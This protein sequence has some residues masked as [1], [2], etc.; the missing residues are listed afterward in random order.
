[1][2]KNTLILTALAL[3]A[4]LSACQEKLNNNHNGPMVSVKFSAGS[5]GS[6]TDISSSGVVTWNANDHLAVFTDVDG[7]N[8]YDFSVSALNQAKTV[9]E[10]SGTVPSDPSRKAVYALYPY[11]NNYTGGPTAVVVGVNSQQISGMNYTFMAGKGAVEGDNFDGVSMEMK[12]LTWIYDV[13]ITNPS[14]K[15]IKAVHFV[16]GTGVFTWNGTVDLTADDPEVSP[17]NLR[18]TMSVVFNTAR[19]SDVTARFALFPLSCTDVDF[20][21]HVEFEDGFYETFALGSRSLN[22]AAGVRKSNTFVLGKGTASQAPWG[23]Y[24]V[25]SGTTIGNTL[26]TSGK[27]ALGGNGV[28]SKLYFEPGG[29]FETGSAKLAPTS[30]LYIASDPDNKPTFTQKVSSLLLPAK[31]AS[32]ETISF[33]NINLVAQMSLSESNILYVSD[34]SLTGISIGSIVFDGCSF[35]DYKNSL[36]R[37]VSGLGSISI[38]SVSMN[39]CIYTVKSSYNGATALIHLI[40]NTDKVDALTMTNNTLVGLGYI[41]Y[42]NLSSANQVNPFV[43]TFE[44]NTMGNMKSCPSMNAF[45]VFQ[46]AISGSVSIQNNLFAG[47]NGHTKDN[48][49]LQEGN[50][51]KFTNVLD[52]NWYAPDWLTF[53]IDNSKTSYINFL[54][55]DST[56]NSSELCPGYA[57]GNF[58]VSAS[59]DVKDAGAGDPRWL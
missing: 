30:S 49:M 42:H 52:N 21:I 24:F 14:A 36:I 46:N 5:D 20:D 16:A 22:V 53:A 29:T 45:F 13:H 26:V 7:S 41:L 54:T 48:R 57:S 37:T 3:T 27:N 44:N 43:L 17:N 28:D 15:A 23:W 56:M 55:D 38:G 19:T 39:N 18:R 40:N 4:V 6:R 50:P 32:I 25:A 51:A 47:S 9:A 8:A 59:S 2:K 1:M 12:H 10:F 34:A 11:K 33:Q 31:D 58:T 35:T